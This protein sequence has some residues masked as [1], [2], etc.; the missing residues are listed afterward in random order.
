M[1]YSQDKFANAATH[2]RAVW[3]TTKSNV[4]AGDTIV[5]ADTSAH[6][7]ELRV[8]QHL[9][10]HM[11]GNIFAD[12]ARY[13]G[14]YRASGM[15]KAQVIEKIVQ[16][17]LI[18]VMR[19]EDAHTATFAPSKRRKHN[20]GKAKK[21]DPPAER[22]PRQEAKKA[23]Y[24]PGTIRVY[25]EEVSSTSGEHVALRLHIIILGTDDE[26][27]DDFSKAL[28]QVIMENNALHRKRL[29]MEPKKRRPFNKYEAWKTVNGMEKWGELVDVYTN[30][31]RC[32]DNYDALMDRK[33]TITTLENPGCPLT[34]FNMHNAIRQ[35]RNNTSVPPEQ[36]N[37][38]EY[39]P[40]GSILDGAG[41]VRIGRR[42]GNL[43]ALRVLGSDMH[44]EIWGIKY[45]PSHQRA[46]STALAIDDVRKMLGKTLHDCRDDHDDQ[47]EGVDP[48]IIAKSKIESLSAQNPS[49]SLWATGSLARCKQ[50]ISSIHRRPGYI[51][52]SEQVLSEITDFCS[53]LWNE[54]VES[55]ISKCGRV[56]FAYSQTR[57]YKPIIYDIEHTLPGRSH[58]GRMVQSWLSRA[59]Y[60]LLIGH[61]QMIIFALMNGRF[62]A[63]DTHF[64]L[65]WNALLTG[66]SSTGKSFAFDQIVKC[67]IEGTVTKYSRRT[68]NA[69]QVQQ[70]AP[71][72]N[73]DVIEIYEEMPKSILEEQ[74]FSDKHDMQKAQM[75]EQRN[76]TVQCWVDADGQRRQVTSVNECIGVRIGATNN[77]L[78]AVPEAMRSRFEVFETQTKTASA[79]TTRKRDIAHMKHAQRKKNATDDIVTQRFLYQNHEEQLRVYLYY[80]LAY[81]GV[82]EMPSMATIQTIHLRLVEGVKTILP[83]C[84]VHSR[85][86][87]R[88]LMHAKTLLIRY[89]I[90]RAF[91]CPGGPCFNK[92]TFQVHDMI[93]AEKYAVSGECAT[94]IAVLSFVMVSHNFLNYNLASVLSGILDIH[95]K[96][97][98]FDEIK[99]ND[100]AMLTIDEIPKNF[101]YIRIPL[102]LPQLSH[103]VSVLMD[104]ERGRLS[105]EI[106]RV[107]I[108]DIGDTKVKSKQFIGPDGAIDHASPITQS[109]AARFEKNSVFIHQQIFIE[110]RDGAMNEII[111][112][113]MHE[114]SKPSTITLGSVHQDDTELFNTIHWHRVPNRIIKHTNLLHVGQQR[115]KLLGF[116]QEDLDMD[117]CH[118]SAPAV[119]VIDRAYDDMAKN[120]PRTLPH[121]I[122]DEVTNAD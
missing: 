15:P 111:Q 34:N 106:V 113:A 90:H 47:A 8:I 62:N 26:N 25:L 28:Y 33:V 32:S 79:L 117:G 98:Q 83:R 97:N 6:P 41:L 94:E 39:H 119:S 36:R 110:N 17:F 43:G 20:S 40:D 11:S 3:V 59:T 56:I 58:F 114:Y 116:T 121:I 75:T 2:G 69:D 53:R 22:D 46:Q 84:R 92:P 48:M 89:A 85:D 88:A 1:A 55:T 78:T 52:T 10:V 80:K 44:P 16:L 57:E 73:N 120:D 30:G 86:E 81:C 13:M 60:H 108:K 50:H 5:G 24:R 103:Q 51:R 115:A 100:G 42:D 71:G 18:T 49:F 68:T 7:S 104:T 9:V 12:G 29:D 65:H 45:R 122:W 23:S 4:N 105:K 35:V 87:Q 101:N 96:H 61:T 67:S 95:N 63:Y 64:G 14:D 37:I 99:P 74:K 19:M 91:N 112:Y 93:H 70:L 102:G 27:D 118:A 31:R 66:A 107:I 21:Q 72:Y 82:L 76:I 38:D 109:V 54:Q 77:P